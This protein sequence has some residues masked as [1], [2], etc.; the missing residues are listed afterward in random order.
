MYELRYRS[1][2]FTTH[3]QQ[4][5]NGIFVHLL[6]VPATVPQSWTRTVH[7]GC[8]YIS[9]TYLG[10]TKAHFTLGVRLRDRSR[11][12]TT[13]QQPVRTVFSYTCCT[14]PRSRTRTVHLG[15]VYINYTYLGGT[16]ADL[17][18]VYQSDAAH[19]SSPHR[20]QQPVANGIFLHLLNS[21]PK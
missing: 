10:G 13:P 5:A 15:C 3:T 8:V 16:V 19:G 1:R 20:T 7:L 4:S 11:Q 18:Q 2:Q 9:Y 14:V 17:H 21:S 12:F 6:Y